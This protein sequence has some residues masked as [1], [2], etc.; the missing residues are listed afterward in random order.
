MKTLVT[1]LVLLLASLALA[2]SPN[3]KVVVLQKEEGERRVRR[4][5]VGM[6]VA[7]AEFILKVTPENSGSTRLVVGTET[8]PPGGRINRHRHLGEDEVLILQTGSARVTLN[9]RSYEVRAGGMVFFPALTWVALENTGGEP[10]ELIFIFSQPGFEKQM[11]CVSVPAGEDASQ[12]L[13]RDE[14]RACIHQGHAEYEALEPE[15]K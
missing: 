4:P 5:R 8:I 2:Q 14:M 9:D 1:L 7:S 6:P 15:K 11:R 12:P 13:T 10:I 3:G